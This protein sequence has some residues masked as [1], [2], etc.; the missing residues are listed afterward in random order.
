LEFNEKPDYLQYID[1]FKSEI[2]VN[3]K[4]C[5]FNNI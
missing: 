4:F 3:Y 2:W 1:F 5:I